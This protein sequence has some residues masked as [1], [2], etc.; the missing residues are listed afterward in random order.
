MTRAQAWVAAL[1]VLTMVGASASALAARSTC[2]VNHHAC[3]GTTTNVC[4]CRLVGP[5][6][7]P[8]ATSAPEVANVAAPAL[9]TT[10][11]SRIPSPHVAMHATPPCRDCVVADR[12]ALFRVLLI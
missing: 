8:P 4:C 3:S 12:L 7:T 6:D 9:L 2:E 5:G 10:D 1:T 11:I